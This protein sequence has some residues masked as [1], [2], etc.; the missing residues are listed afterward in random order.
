[1][2]TDNLLYMLAKVDQRDDTAWVV[3]IDM[4]RAVVEAL[5]P[6]STKP[7]CTPTLHC[8]CAFPKYCTTQL[9]MI[10]SRQMMVIRTI[11]LCKVTCF[12][13]VSAFANSSSADHWEN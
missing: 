6:V 3:V 13:T 2:R 9:L 7:S 10:L 8:P 4:G 12:V 5:V 11:T 1:V